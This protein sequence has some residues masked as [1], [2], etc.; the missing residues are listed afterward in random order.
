MTTIDDMHL[1][2]EPRLGYSRYASRPLANSS[3]G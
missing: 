1:L 3:I 2:V